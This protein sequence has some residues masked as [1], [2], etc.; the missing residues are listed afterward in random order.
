M[1]P[2]ATP[3]MPDPL[4]PEELLAR[5]DLAGRAR[6]IAVRKIPDQSCRIA[7]LRFDNLMKGTPKF[8]SRV[9]SWLPWGRTVLVRMRSA[10]RGAD[11][12]LMPGEWS[13]GYRAG[14]TVMT[15]L[16]WDSD[17]QIYS[18]VWWNA[19]WQAPLG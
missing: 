1:T 9:M 7:E 12:G 15:H 19:V 3:R 5:A 10:K 16:V 11:G 4:S 2:A 6:V 8:H 18:T 17:A 14:D 13:D